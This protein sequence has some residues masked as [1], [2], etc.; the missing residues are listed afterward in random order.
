MAITPLTVTVSEDLEDR[1]HLVQIWSDLDSLCN[2][3]TLLIPDTRA[4]STHVENRGQNNILS[5]LFDKSSRADI[6]HYIRFEIGGF[7][8]QIL[9]ATYQKLI[10]FH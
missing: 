1:M 3:L 9:V 5:E 7:F 6:L 10:V 8:F 2:R 4:L